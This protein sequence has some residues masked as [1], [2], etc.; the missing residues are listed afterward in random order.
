MDLQSTYD[1]IAAHFSKTREH[2]WPEVESFLEGRSGTLALDV[3]CGNGRHTEALATRAETAVGVDLSRGLLDE[4]AAR[5]LGR[6]F[7]DA[8]EFV[9]GDAAALPVRDDA[10]DLGVYVATLHHL[11]PR[12]ARIES[13]NELARALAPGGVA[14]VSAWSTAHDRFD[15]DDGFDTTV[16]WTLPGGET[17][18]RYYHI[19]SPSEFESD[20]DE[21]ALETLETAV[22]SGNC[23]AT[24]S[25]PDS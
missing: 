24:V 5:A 9:H 2:A 14:L 11:S 19:Y 16:D 7:A 15:R 21:S 1:R 20:L 17:V 12:A 18:P 8:T 22:S 6:G 25:A 10:V 13:L 23:Y 3:G 4:A